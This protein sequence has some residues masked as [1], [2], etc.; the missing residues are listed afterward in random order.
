MQPKQSKISASLMPLCS[1]GTAH[2]AS[3]RLKISEM[4]RET[5]PFHYFL[6]PI[7]FL[8]VRAGCVCVGFAPSILRALFWQT[9]EARYTERDTVNYWH[10]NHNIRSGFQYFLPLHSCCGLQ[11]FETIYQITPSSSLAPAVLALWLFPYCKAP[12]SVECHLL[13]EA[14]SD[15]PTTQP[16]LTFFKE[17]ITRKIRIW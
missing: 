5:I 2:H 16:A 14:L 13:Q 10:H 17:F 1:L 9:L 4:R 3:L 12:V 11:W 6:R 8:T 7:N 15:H